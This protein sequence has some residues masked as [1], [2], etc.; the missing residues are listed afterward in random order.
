MLKKLTQEQQDVILERAIEEFGKNGPERAAIS[1]IARRSG[2]SV[3]VI[4]KYYDNKEALFDHCL[5]HSIKLLTRVMNEAVSGEDDLWHACEKLIRACISF[6]KE[7]APYIQMYHAITGSREDAG[8]YAA[9]IESVTASTYTQLIEKARQEK[10]VRKDLDP[11]LCAM[12]F[13]NLLMMLH[14]SYGCEYYR[15]RMNIYCGRQM[16]SEDYATK[17]MMAFLRG[18]LSS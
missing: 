8:K 7:H 12:F 18:A 11:A 9:A 2:V 16:D 14:F 17:Q 4:Y 5:K 6:S 15:E 13:D 10:A 1:Q 3:G